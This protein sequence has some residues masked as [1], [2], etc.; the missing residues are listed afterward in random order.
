MLA[1]I[2]ATYLV[3][4]F[5]FQYRI[6]AS[7]IYHDEVQDVETVEGLL[8]FESNGK[9]QLQ[10]NYFSRPQSHLLIDR[11]MEVRDLSGAVLYRTPNLGGV[12]LGGSTMPGEGDSSFNQR[13]VRMPD[14]SHVSLISH[15]HTL[16]GHVL[17]IRLGYSL[18][19]FHQRMKQFL[20]ILLLAF[21]V[22]L[23]LAGIAGYQIAKRAFVP[24]EEMARKAKQITASNLHD[25]LRI[26]DA[27][28]ELGH[29]GQAFNE[30]LD[31]LE[32]AFQQLNSFTADAAHELRTPLAAIRAVGEVSLQQPAT[33][34][35]GKEAVVSMLEEA[36]RLDET[37]S[38]LLLLA[39]AERAGAVGP[40][41]FSL[42]DVV[43][44]VAEVLEVLAEER[45]I[46]LVTSVRDE[47]HNA[48]VT[49][50][51][52]LIRSAI[53]NVVHNAIKFSPVDSTVQITYSVSDTASRTIEVV[54]QDQGP[55]IPLAEVDAVFGRFY[56]GSSKNGHESQSTGLGLSIAKLVVE[57]SGGEIR[58]DRHTQTGARCVIRLPA[59]HLR[60]TS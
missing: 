15:L 57:R 11:L 44:E 54:V 35:R 28:D 50:D 55:G 34:E 37:I 53:M 21:P 2:L 59:H 9:L 19:P 12:S 39:R 10:Q 52:S 45:R 14:G 24:L 33:S 20:G 26:A 18:V 38:G 4:V 7:Q 36:S 60:E 22:A 49:G 31:R 51:R 40:N 25:R 17:L 23:I 16:Q 46:R 6:V 42:V 8:Y 48:V 56:T 13:I 30:L 41:R 3:V 58:F 43:H 32:Q 27:N 29:M 47:E 5:L 1:A